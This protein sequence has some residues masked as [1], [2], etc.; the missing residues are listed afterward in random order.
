[1]LGGVEGLG[2][3]VIGAL[4]APEH[5]GRGAGTAAQRLLRDLLFD[6]TP[7]NRLCAYTETDNV[8]EQRSLEKCGFVREGVLRQA[9]FRGGQWRDLVS[10][11]C[12]REDA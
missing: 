2:G 12:L 10:Y 7:A 1:M 4:L 9:A 8:V 6:T 5:R 3:W 11:G